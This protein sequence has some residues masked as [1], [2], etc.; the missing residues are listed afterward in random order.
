MVVLPVLHLTVFAVGRTVV[1]RLDPA[2]QY[3]EASHFIPNAS[4]ILGRPVT[5]G[6]D[7]GV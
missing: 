6:D 5:P 1:A 3:A 7:S 4:G 2:I